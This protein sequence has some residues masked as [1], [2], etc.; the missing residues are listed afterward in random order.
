MVEQVVITLY[1][2]PPPFELADLGIM[3]LGRFVGSKA[4]AK[5]APMR[6]AK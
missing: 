6:F 3:I 2:T 4:V 5:G 1:L